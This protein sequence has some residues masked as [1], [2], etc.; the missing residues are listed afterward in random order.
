MSQPT[1]NTFLVS[2]GLNDIGTFTI[3]FTVK[4]V[5]DGMAPS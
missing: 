4:T 5:F 3:E 1:K 2:S